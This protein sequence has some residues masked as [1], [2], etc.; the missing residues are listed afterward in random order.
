MSTWRPHGHTSA[1]DGAGTQ[2]TAVI[3]GDKCVPVCVYLEQQQKRRCLA[4]WLCAVSVHLHPFIPSNVGS[5]EVFIGPSQ[6]LCM[7]CPF[8]SCMPLP[9]SS[10]R[11]D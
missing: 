7:P 2:K 10:R 8:F 11:E 9:E 4:A 5:G 1:E 3:L 6:L